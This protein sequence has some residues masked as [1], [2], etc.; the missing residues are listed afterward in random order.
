MLRKYWNQSWM[1]PTA[2]FVAAVAPQNKFPL[3]SKF[4]RNPGRMPKTSSTSGK[5]MAGFLVKSFGGCC[6]LTVLTGASCWPPNNCISAQK[7]V[8]MSTELNHN[9]SAL[10]LD[11]GNGVCYHHSSIYSPYI[12]VLQ[13]TAR[14]PNLTCEAMSSLRKTHFANNEKIIYLREMCWSSRM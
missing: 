12:R 7:I 13:T 2:V 9:R 5:Y 10:V 1:I 3:S 11:S 8:S 14:G 4:S 6:G